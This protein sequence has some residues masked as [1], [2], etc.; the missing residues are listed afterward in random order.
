MTCFFFFQRLTSAKRKILEDLELYY[1]EENGA[2]VEL[3]KSDQRLKRKHACEK[4]VMVPGKLDHASVVAY[5]VGRYTKEDDTDVA[6][7][8][9]NLR[10][11]NLEPSSSTSD[12]RKNADVGREVRTQDE[13][14]L[15]AKECDDR[16]KRLSIYDN[17]CSAQ[18]ESFETSL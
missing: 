12:E 11:C 5:N 2:I 3:S 4:L 1:T 17:D 10:D 6:I 18:E 8:N 15:N 13:I 16:S 9:L 7:P 14:N